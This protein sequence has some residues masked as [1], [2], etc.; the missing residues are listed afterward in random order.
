MTPLS[1][2][3]GLLGNVGISLPELVA[4]G[5]ECEAAGSAGVWM[6]EYEYDALAM[7]QAVAGATERV[8]TGTCITRAFTRHPI[9]MA[10]SAVVVDRL[11]PGRFVIG[12][13][14]GA[15]KAADPTLSMQRWGQEWDKPVGRMREYVQILRRAMTG[16]TITYDGEFF[17][18][19]N[20]RLDPVPSTY[21]PIY[22]A[23]GGERMSEV[24]GA[25]ADGVFVH[26]V[27]RE[28]TERT[29]E[30]VDRGARGAGR[31]PSAI[32]LSNLIMVCVDEERELAYDAMRHWLVDFY[33][34]M[35]SY[36]KV[37][38]HGGYADVAN[39]VRDRL[40]AGDVAGA[41]AA[42][43]DALLEEFTMVGT[44]ADCERK[45]AEIVSWGTSIPILY[46]FPS[47]DDWLDGYRRT[48]A[49]FAGAGRSDGAIA[50]GSRTD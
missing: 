20:I 33:L 32:E 22:I 29:R 37:L 27:N 19:R 35:P 44:P 50:A 40:T 5:R 15:L 4:F 21:V 3:I 24:A 36:Q 39:V 1:P 28:K 42:L 25:E 26:L 13:G 23:A 7:A 14:T 41:E 17:Q 31:D 6:V 12:L 43:P 48:L 47:R 8:L 16:E 10:E 45:L 18:L 30:A 49:A 46:P 34:N 9:S 2:G 11:A 38:E